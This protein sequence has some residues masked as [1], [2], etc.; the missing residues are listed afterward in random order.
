MQI[1]DFF[2]G[3]AG[4]FFA[5][6][7]LAGA[8]FCTGIIGASW[9]IINATGQNEILGKYWAVALISS[10]IT[11]VS[12]GG[13]IDKYNK[14]TIIQVCCAGQAFLFFLTAGLYAAGTAHIYIIYGLAL[15]NMPLT[16]V[17]GA[18]ARGAVPTVLGRD[19]LHHGNSIIEITAQAGAMIAALLTGLLYRAFGFGVL[20]FTG[21]LL[22]AGAAILLAFAKNI[23]TREE[24]SKDTFLQS[25]FKGLI[26]LKARKTLLLYGAAVFTPSIV[27]VVLNTVIPGYVEQHLGKD[28]IVFGIGDMLFSAGAMLAG[29]ITAGIF[30]GKNRFFMQAVFFTGAV[31]SLISFGAVQ[32]AAWF[33]AAVFVNGALLA[34][35]RVILNTTLM[36]AVSQRYLGRCLALLTALSLVLQAALAYITG[37]L[38]DSLG[39]VY[40]YYAL[41]L[42]AA[43]GFLLFLSSKSAAQAAAKSA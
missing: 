26:Y 29:F 36:E 6:N 14:I 28:S 25:F 24:P 12:A 3:G 41:A 38:M 35:L 21:A 33:Y 17:F 42:V 32:S 20:I 27:I 9:F 34:G 2:R 5:V 16:A 15:L 11:L 39:A 13:L 37:T 10:F 7:A 30:R 8:G 1:R 31:F 40:G 23:F 4:L 19:R 43:A 18:A 22:L